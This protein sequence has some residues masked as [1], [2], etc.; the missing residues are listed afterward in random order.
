M[1]REDK[2]QT[3]T[4][5]RPDGGRN[6]GRAILRSAAATSKAFNN[7]IYMSSLPEVTSP[8]VVMAT[9]SQLKD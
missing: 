1:R 2:L 8:A 7:L 9:Q 6:G 3:W 4:L 5:L